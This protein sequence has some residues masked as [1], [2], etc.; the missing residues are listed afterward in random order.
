[1]ALDAADIR[2]TRVRKR[3][4][5]KEFVGEDERDGE[6]FVESSFWDEWSIGVSVEWWSLQSKPLAEVGEAENDGTRRQTRLIEDLFG[7]ETKGCPGFV[8]IDEIATD[9]C[10]KVGHDVNV[11]IKDGHHTA[12]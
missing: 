3:I 4:V 6:I 2:P 5:V 10:D 7:E 1:V 11:V 8:D 9:V 12:G